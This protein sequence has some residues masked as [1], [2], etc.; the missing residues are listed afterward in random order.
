LLVDDLH[1]AGEDELLRSFA[2]LPGVQ[3]RLFNPLPVRG[4]SLAMRL[5]LS[6]REFGRINHRMH[7]KLFIADNRF[8]ISGGRNMADEYFMRS[9]LANFIDVDVIAAGSVVREQSAVFDR[10]WNSEQAWPIESIV[11]L[12]LDA[13]AA[14]RH[15]D[16]LS[17]AAMADPMLE[18]TDP[19]GGRPVGVELAV[20]QVSLVFARAEVFADAPAKVV[21]H[22]RSETMA[23]VARSILE[24]LNE[25]RRE[26]L[27]ASPYFIPGPSG[28]ATIKEACDRGVHIALITNSLGAT[29]EPLSTGATP[30]TGATCCVWASTS[31]SSART[32]RAT[33][34]DS[35]TSARL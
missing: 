16:A 23:T 18:A 12:P 7:N 13:D 1:T 17:R 9:D 11:A 26:V 14:Q 8:S 32:L 29:D 28:M 5:L 10:Y 6:L 31:T 30:A 25:A 35:A 33:S 2:A 34:A 20:G 21:R 15:F 24:S 22:A 4:D 19:M 3:V 27:L